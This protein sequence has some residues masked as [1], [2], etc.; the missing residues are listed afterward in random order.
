M[1]TWEVSLSRF[2][3]AFFFEQV[4]APRDSKQQIHRL[5]D[6]AFVAVRQA[7]STQAEECSRQAQSDLANRLP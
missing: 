4:G 1:V 5:G 2:T 3:L 6:R 7:P